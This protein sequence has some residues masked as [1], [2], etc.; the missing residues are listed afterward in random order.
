MQASKDYLDTQIESNTL[1]AASN[2]IKYTP[3]PEDDLATDESTSPLIPY[4]LDIQQED[5][6]SIDVIQLYNV[7]VVYICKDRK[8]PT[9]EISIL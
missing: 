7:C 6:L 5:N 1:A 2:S 8:K 3:S 4:V 9:K